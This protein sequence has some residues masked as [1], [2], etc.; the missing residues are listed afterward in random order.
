MCPPENLPQISQ[1]D[2]VPPSL[3]WQHSALPGHFPG[4][5]RIHS[6][7]HC[8]AS[9]GAEPRWLDIAP[10]LASITHCGKAHVLLCSSVTGTSTLSTFLSRKEPASPTDDPSI[11]GQVWPSSVHLLRAFS[12]PG[13]I[14][15]IVG[16]EYEEQLLPSRNSGLQKPRISPLLFCHGSQKYRNKGPP[17]YTSKQVQPAREWKETLS[18][19]SLQIRRW[20]S[21]HK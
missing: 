15:S 3:L 7:S 12:V 1:L 6:L 20:D 21:W 17:S 4:H 18:T 13:T 16:T 5:I 8:T 9:Q 14:W 10:A 19:H 2:P 11:T